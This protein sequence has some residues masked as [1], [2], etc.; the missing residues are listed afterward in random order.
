MIS[1]DNHFSKE[2][3]WDFIIELLQN[4]EP[5]EEI[6]LKKP[7]GGRGYTMLVELEMN[8]PKLYIKFEWS[9]GNKVVFGRSFHY[10]DL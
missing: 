1:F 3:A 5:V 8:M 10:S 6:E 9:S 7:L 2:S 4:D